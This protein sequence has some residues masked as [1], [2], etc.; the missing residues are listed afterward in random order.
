MQG[1]HKDKNTVYLIGDVGGTNGRFALTDGEDYWNEISLNCSDYDSIAS[2]IEA[3]LQEAGVSQGSTRPKIAA[4]DIAGPAGEGDYVPF[5]NIEGWS[6]SKAAVCN[7]LGLD[8]FFVC[9]DF[10]ALSLGVLGLKEGH[11]YQADKV[12]LAEGESSAPIIVIGP[13]TGLGTSLLVFDE[14]AEDYVPH[15]MEGGHTL[16]NPGT[17]ER[18]FKIIKALTADLDPSSLPEPKDITQ[19][20]MEHFTGQGDTDGHK[21]CREA[22]DRMLGFLGRRTAD[23]T[24]DNSAPPKAVFI[25]GGIVPALDRSYFEQSPYHDAFSYNGDAG[26]PR[27]R[28]ANA[29]SFVVT[30]KYPAF[31]GLMEYL[32]REVDRRAAHL[33]MDQAYDDLLPEPD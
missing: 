4:I 15:P 33:G 5:T 13:G 23:M 24:L 19:M 2:L 8:D 16:A 17:N 6:F 18:D 3:Y 31:L 21:A 26:K 22:V 28:V 9:N 11:Y 14:H 10:F 32:R 20:A 30:H 27:K 12:Q 7:K 25:G 29:P 1:S